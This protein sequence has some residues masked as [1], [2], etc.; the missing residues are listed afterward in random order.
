MCKHET[1]VLLGM[2]FF[3][4]APNAKMER[5]YYW[6]H[7]AYAGKDIYSLGTLTN[8][9]VAWLYTSLNKREC[10][11]YARRLHGEEAIFCWSVLQRVKIGSF[12]QVPASLTLNTG[13]VGG[14][15]INR[16]LSG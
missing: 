9:M 6:R 14:M 11:P 12:A 7:I 10:K 8:K 13:R 3:F 4:A 16:V 1:S 2:P 5:G 15:N